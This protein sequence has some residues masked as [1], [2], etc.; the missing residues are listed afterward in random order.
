MGMMNTYRVVGRYMSGKEIIGYHFLCSDNS[1]L[2]LDREKTIYLINK[3]LVE[4]MRLS[5]SNGEIIIRGKGVNLNALP[6]YDL[7]KEQYR[8]DKA[9]QNVA[10]TSVKDRNGNVQN[11]MGQYKIVKRIMQKNNCIGYVVIDNSGN[12]SKLSRKTIMELAANKRIANA[13]VNKV[14]DNSTGEISF[15]LRGVGC[16]LAQLPIM[17]VSDDGRIVD[18]TSN[19]KDIVIRAIRMKSG[20]QIIYLKDNSTRRFAA[21]DFIIVQADGK[22]N[23]VPGQRFISDYRPEKSH[24]MATCD[25]YIDRVANYAVE[26][27]GSNAITLNPNQVKVWTMA[28]HI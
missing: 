23:V 26:V 1:S 19:K 27:Y 28:K 22:L 10:A 25:Y 3:G 21:G 4:N 13:V 7:N 16:K 11:N 12:E 17:I 15:A 6:V 20:G 18:P 5:S 9:S 24:D 8:S 14:I 2:P